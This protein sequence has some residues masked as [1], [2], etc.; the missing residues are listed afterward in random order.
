MLSKGKFFP[1]LMW[2]LPLIFF[3]YQMILRL[4]PSL[5]MNQI[6]KQFSANAYDFGV[7][8]SLYYYGYSVMQIPIAFIIERFGVRYT[9]FYCA[10][11]CSIATLIFSYTTNWYILC[12]SRFLIGVGSAAA[13]LGVSTVIREWFQKS[14]YAKMVSLSFS[15][16]LLGAVYGGKPMSVLISN[17]T[18]EKVS[19][20]L[21]LM[22][23]VIGF[24][25]FVFLRKPNNTFNESKLECI[26][27]TNVRK[28]FASPSLL[29]LGI[30]SLLM[31]GSL[32]GF[33][34]VWGVNYL[35]NAYSINKT[36]AAGLASFIFVGMIFGGP[37][38]AF[39][40]RLLGNYLVICICGF[41]IAIIFILLINSINYN[42][43]WLASLF[44]IL[45]LMCCYQVIVFDAGLNL[46]NSQLVVVT[47]AFLNC[48]NMLGGSFF[49]TIFG[50]TMDIF[51]TG[52][53]I[54]GI[55]QYNLY[56]YKMALM[57]IPTCSILGTIIV[58]LIHFNLQ[59]RGKILKL[60]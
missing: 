25:I 48:I 46:V 7:L 30:S 23:I 14:Q 43:Y 32:E 34:D 28:V 19:F 41:G 6:I 21:S 44:F 18:Y 57:T 8:V 20:S 52:T 55:R 1:L 15:I 58:W 3:T 36:D 47:I 4:W 51:W 10:I 9:L 35:I 54:N 5:I 12:I 17:Y 59:D 45:G 24:T 2:I 31:V 16:G 60:S 29:L 42:W 49:H 22:S 39:L 13:F 50:L 37:L 26:K 56:S 11:L 53:E 40:A 38:L 27:N 33:A